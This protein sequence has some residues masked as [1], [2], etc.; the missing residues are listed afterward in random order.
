MTGSSA[1]TG[2]PADIQGG[3]TSGEQSSPSAPSAAVGHRRPYHA[4]KL[5]HLGSVR[6]L[7]LGSTAGMPEGGATFMPA[8]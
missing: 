3:S 8:M 2:S 6:E 7:T 1:K 5:R 4:P